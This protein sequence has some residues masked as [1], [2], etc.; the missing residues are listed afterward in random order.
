[1]PAWVISSIAKTRKTAADRRQNA[2][3]SLRKTARAATATAT[4]RAKLRKVPGAPSRKKS[5]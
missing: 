1:M 3:P 2:A 5:A 4:R